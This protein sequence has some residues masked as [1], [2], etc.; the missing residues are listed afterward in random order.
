MDPSPRATK[1][2]RLTGSALGPADTLVRAPNALFYVNKSEDNRWGHNP[3]QSTRRACVQECCSEITSRWDSS[4]LTRRRLPPRVLSMMKTIR[5]VLDS[6]WLEKAFNEPSMSTKPYMMLYVP[7][8]I[9]AMSLDWDLSCA[10]PFLKRL[11][12][13][14]E[15]G[16]V[17]GKGSGKNDDIDMVLSLASSIWTK[18]NV[19]EP[20]PIC[21]V[22]VH[23]RTHKDTTSRLKKWLGP[24]WTVGIAI[25][26]E[27]DVELHEE[28]AHSI[29]WNEGTRAVTLILAHIIGLTADRYRE[30]HLEK[31]A[32]QQTLEEG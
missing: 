10:Y 22:V 32:N 15:N 17:C 26:G 20:V 1:Q 3:H 9:L 31:G 5:H 12:H 11:C 28:S 21:P 4:D 24:I 25:K 6:I 30:W 7:P 27:S 29:K 8:I 23:N 19:I 14:L 13:E 18:G 16:V 2:A